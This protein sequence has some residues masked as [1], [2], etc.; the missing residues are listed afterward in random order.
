VRGDFVTGRVL[1]T[2]YLGFMGTHLVKFLEDKG[3]DVVATYF[4]PSTE[5]RLGKPKGVVLECDVR[6][7]EGVF[8]ILREFRPHKIFHLAAQSYPAVSWDDPWY[9][10]ETNV[11]GTVNIFEGVKQLDLDCSILNACS[12]AEYGFVADHEVPVREEHALNPLQP[13]G[14]SKVAQEMLGYQYFKNFGIKSIAVRIFNTTG[15]GKVNDVCS[16]FTKRVTEIKKGMNLERKL[17]VGN[18]ESR[19]AITDVRD[20]IQAFDLALEKASFGEAYNLSGAKVYQTREIVEIIR[21]LVGF[22]FAVEQDPTLLRPT[23]EPII[24]GSSEKFQEQTDWKQEI[25]LEE[26]L[27]DMLS[28]WDEVLQVA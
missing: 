17:R 21:A 7:R 2:G 12:S 16:D 25:P 8:R 4:R 14:V 24:F 5:L 26:T 22:D 6:D 15:P 20:V 9:T 1:I 13:Y 19:R 23:D 10:V 18:L 3:Y 27:R 11:I 28:Y